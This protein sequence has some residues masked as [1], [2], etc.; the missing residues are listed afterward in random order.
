[1]TS[2]SGGGHDYISWQG[3]LADGLQALMEIA[4][5]EGEIK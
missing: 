3:T 2:A 5:S 4:A 1:M